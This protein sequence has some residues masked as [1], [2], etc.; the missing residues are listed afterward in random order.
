MV[1]HEDELNYE[2]SSCVYESDSKRIKKKEGFKEAYSVKLIVLFFSCM[3]LWNIA[4]LVELKHVR[5][6]TGWQVDITLTGESVLNPGPCSLFPALGRDRSTRHGYYQQFEI[7]IYEGQHIRSNLNPST[8]VYSFKLG[9]SFLL[10][11][12]ASRYKLQVNK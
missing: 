8:Y 9:D 12:I 7:V 6:S 1:K 4:A 3:Y 11:F 5:H 10:L 2:I